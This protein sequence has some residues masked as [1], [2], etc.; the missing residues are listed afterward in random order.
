VSRNGYIFEGLNI[1][2][3][4]FCVCADGIQDISKAFHYPKQLSL[5][6]AEMLSRKYGVSMDSHLTKE[7]LAIARSFRSVFFTLIEVHKTNTREMV[8]LKS[9][10]VGVPDCTRQH[11]R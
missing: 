9:F 3:S 1:L 5:I 7:Q 11:D 8:A 10:F 6:R 2:M 4:T